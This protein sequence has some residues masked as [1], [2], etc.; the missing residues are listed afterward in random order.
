MR[1]DSVAR[2]RRGQINGDDPNPDAPLDV[3]KVHVRSLQP[4][5]TNIGRLAE[6]EIDFSVTIG[7]EGDGKDPRDQWARLA[8]S[9]AYGVAYFVV[10]DE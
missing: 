1:E 10:P 3:I 7:D 9:L 2:I 6:I 5:I 4:S 8:R